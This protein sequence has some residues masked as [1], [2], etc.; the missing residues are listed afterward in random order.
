MRIL[1]FDFNN[2]LHDVEEELMRRGHEILPHRLPNGQLQDWRK[3]EVIIVWQETDLGGWKDT[4]RMWQKAG[5][6]VILMQHGR[7]GTSRIFPPFNEELVSDYLCVWGE[8]DVTRMTSCGVPREKIF[9][10]GTPVVTHVKPRIPHKGINV[11]FSPEHWDQEVAENFIVRNALREFVSRRWFWQPKVKITTKILAGEHQPYNYDNP[12]SSNRQLPGHLEK[13]VEVL[14]T[15]DAVVAISESTFELL[16]EIM[17]IPVIIADIWVPKACAGDERYKT[18][19]REYSP[20]CERVKDVNKLG[21]AIMRHVSNPQLLH[22]ERQEIGILDGGTNIALPVDEII[23]V[24][25]HAR[26]NSKRS[27][28]VSRTRHPRK[29]SVRRG[30][31]KRTVHGTA[32]QVRPKGNRN[33]RKS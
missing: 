31:R 5:I 15:A 2:I 26:N 3:A 11:V 23:K 22:K 21:E 17:D 12:V 14:R 25:E 10:T 29:S 16:A 9:V 1:S 27:S 18:Y 13:A 19:Q 20:A 8:N 32:R 33:R 7:R 28:S 30:V 24:I 4:I 6:P